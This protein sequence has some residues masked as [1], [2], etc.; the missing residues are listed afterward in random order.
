VI[1]IWTK[2]ENY[3]SSNTSTKMK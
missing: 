1:E 2:Q 3:S